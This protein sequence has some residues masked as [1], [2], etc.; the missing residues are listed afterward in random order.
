MEMFQRAYHDQQSGILLSVY[1]RTDACGGHV[2]GVAAAW[3]AGRV[4]QHTPYSSP[5]T[6]IVMEMMEMEECSA[7]MQ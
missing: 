7:P 5:M 3:G 6:S 4:P 2:G 1:G